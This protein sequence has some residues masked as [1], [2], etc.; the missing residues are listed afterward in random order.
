MS[1][2]LYD[3]VNVCVFLCCKYPGI[4]LGEFMRK[5]QCEEGGCLFKAEQPTSGVNLHSSFDLVLRLKTS[6]GS[7]EMHLF[8]F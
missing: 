7:E 8:V 3:E 4:H 2:Y 5:E 1:V 6:G